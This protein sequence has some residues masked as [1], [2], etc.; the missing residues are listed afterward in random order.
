MAK[1]KFIIDDDE[2]EQ[3]QDY[4]SHQD[5]DD[6]YE[7]ASG[8]QDTEYV[9]IPTLR[10][11]QSRSALTASASQNR[12]NEGAQGESGDGGVSPTLEDNTPEV[13]PQSAAEFPQVRIK[14]QHESPRAISSSF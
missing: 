11:T 8:D 9:S 14:I 2:D 4:Q 6:D 7:P 5:S 12:D 3:D 13:P 1:R 10:V